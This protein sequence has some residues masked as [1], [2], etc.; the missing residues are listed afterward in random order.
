VL[1]SGQVLKTGTFFVDH[2]GGA[3]PS[4][5]FL[6]WGTNNGPRE[7]AAKVNAQFEISSWALSGKSPAQQA[8]WWEW[9]EGILVADSVEF[10]PS[11][12]RQGRLPALTAQTELM[13]TEVGMPLITQRDCTPI[14][15]NCTR[16]AIL[17]PQ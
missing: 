8:G 3:L 14:Y 6:A 1:V 7:W 17:I 10:P 15:Y 13:L 12:S 4:A 16:N 11:Q 5:F 9:R 2:G